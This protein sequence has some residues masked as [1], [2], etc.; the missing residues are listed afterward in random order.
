MI[1]N[2]QT[3]ISKIISENEDAI[4]VIAAINQNFLKLKNPFLRKMLA[5]RVS[6]NDAAQIG[7][8]NS[9]E[10]LLA[11]EKIGFEIELEL[12]ET[13]TLQFN[14]RDRKSVV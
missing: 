2:K 13:N 3:R 5:P 12:E 11:L 4:E 1:I 8:S 14:N 6:I 9:N 10:I 7:N